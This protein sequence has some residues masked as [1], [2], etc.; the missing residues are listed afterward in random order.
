VCAS[1]IHV[2]S[3]V[4]LQMPDVDITDDQ[5]RA[6]PRVPMRCLHPRHMLTSIASHLQV[7]IVS[8]QGF[9]EKKGLAI[10]DVNPRGMPRMFFRLC[11]EV[12]AICLLIR[13]R[14]ASGARRHPRDVMTRFSQFS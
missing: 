4:V 9:G 11:A 13:T 8:V 6:A 5:A 12:L 14:R 3:V 10:K 7:G 1:K 2:P